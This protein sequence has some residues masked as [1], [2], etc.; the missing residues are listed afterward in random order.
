MQ[1]K[2]ARESFLWKANH[3]PPSLARACKQAWQP[4]ENGWEMNNGKICLQD[5]KTKRG[6]AA[7]LNYIT[8]FI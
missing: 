4:R 3:L 2:A 8:G 5:T 1:L 6:S 7:N